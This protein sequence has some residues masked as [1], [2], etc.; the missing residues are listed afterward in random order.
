MNKVASKIN[1]NA[2]FNHYDPSINDNDQ[3]EMLLFTGFINEINDWT[4][5]FD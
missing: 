4:I 5:K 1:F 2:P 3:F